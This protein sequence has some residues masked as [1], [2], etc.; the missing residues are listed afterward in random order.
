MI[1][2]YYLPGAASL[3]PHLALEEAGAEYRLVRVVR[4]GGRVVSP[5]DY[6]KLNP[7]GRVPALVDDGMALHESAAIVMHVA[8]RF[9]AAGL[10]PEPG[11]LERGDWYRWHVYLTNTAQAAFIDFFGPGRAV[12]DE[13][14]QQALKAGAIE[15]LHRIRDWIEGE[16]AT[17][18][19]WLLGERFSSADLFLAMLVRWGRNLPD[20]W[21]DAPRLGTLYRAVRERPA[22]QRVWEQQGLDV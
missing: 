13:A 17:R 12:A 20:A 6:L 14:A 21:W 10:A 16:L 4:E 22:A 3:A 11:T 9:P 7:H 1:E 8:D 18:G 5:P 2:L 19:P 15:R